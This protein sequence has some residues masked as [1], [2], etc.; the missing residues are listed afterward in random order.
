MGIL[1][2]LLFV[3][4]QPHSSPWYCYPPP[5]PNCFA[6][7]NYTS[8]GFPVEIAGLALTVTGVALV[9]LVLGILKTKKPTSS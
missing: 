5:T 4:S 7:P 2:P 8:W 6:N 3:L 9:I 1:G